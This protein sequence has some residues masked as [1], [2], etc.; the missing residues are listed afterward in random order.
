MWNWREVS[1]TGEAFP[2]NPASLHVFPLRPSQ[3]RLL[4][5]QDLSCH[6]Y[7][8][9]V[10]LSYPNARLQPRTLILIQ[11]P[12]V[13][14][15]LINYQ[16]T[17][18]YLHLPVPQH[19][20]VLLTAPSHTGQVLEPLFLGRRQRLLLASSLSGTRGLLARLSASCIF[21]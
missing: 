11:G 21:L 13:G 19:T 20:P 16:Q 8:H 17:G 2:E 14:K 5:L 10:Q 9:D 1:F 18:Q 12:S 4:H 15:Q 7:T 3:R 6:L